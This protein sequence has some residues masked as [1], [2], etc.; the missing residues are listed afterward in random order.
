MLDGENQHGRAFTYKCYDAHPAETPQ[1]IKWRNSE[2][3]ELK[4][5]AM[6]SIPSQKKK[7]VLSELGAHPN[8]TL[9]SPH[10]FNVIH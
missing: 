5:K 8:E 9:L 3:E 2:N 4:K 7:N 6:T 1:Q 10:P